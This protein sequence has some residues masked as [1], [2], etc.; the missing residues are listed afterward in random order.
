[1]FTAAT[2]ATFARNVVHREIFAFFVLRIQV[3]LGLSRLLIPFPRVV[4]RP[5]RFVNGG[6]KRD[7]RG[8]REHGVNVA[9]EYTP[10]FDLTCVAVIHKHSIFPQVI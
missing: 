4:S 6:L 7:C 2:A 1:M 3:L 10:V 9:L 5:P 8:H